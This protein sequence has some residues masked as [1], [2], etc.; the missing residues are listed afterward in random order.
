MENHMHTSHFQ[1]GLISVLSLALGISLSSSAAEGYPAGATVS[2]GSN[3][4]INSGG[5]I[6][7]DGRFE[8]IA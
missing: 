5:A 4:I 2:T 6:T 1:L 3:P 7:T 8:V